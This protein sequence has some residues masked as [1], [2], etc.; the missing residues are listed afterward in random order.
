[1][2]LQPCVRL[3]NRPDRVPLSVIGVRFPLPCLHASRNSPR[4]RLDPALADL[5]RQQAAPASDLPSHHSQAPP[6]ASSVAY[7]SS[8]SAL[9]IP[10]A[11]IALPA[12]IGWS[13]ASAII[14]TP[15]QSGSFEI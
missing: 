2:L 14:A 9:S 12:S 7:C 6:I 4:L 13:S 15:R 1:V 11:R 5:L 10:R 3:D 8:S